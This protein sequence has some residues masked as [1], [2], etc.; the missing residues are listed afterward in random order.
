MIIVL[1][2]I[3]YRIEGSFLFLLHIE[4]SIRNEIIGSQNLKIMERTEDMGIFLATL[5]KQIVTSAQLFRTH[6]TSESVN[7]GTSGYHI[8]SKTYKEFDRM[9]SV[10]LRIEIKLRREVFLD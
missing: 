1:F 9:T 3:N 8:T 2:H 5:F 4:G 6:K 10:L 7:N